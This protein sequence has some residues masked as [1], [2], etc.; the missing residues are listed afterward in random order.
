MKRYHDVR[1]KRYHDVPV[2]LYNPHRK[3]G[4]TPKVQKPWEGPYLVIKRIIDLVYCIQLSPCSRPKVVHMERLW[5]YQGEDPPSWLSH[6]HTH[7][8]EPESESPGDENPGKRE[9]SDPSDHVNKEENDSMASQSHE[10]T[11]DE[12]RQSKRTRH[13]P[14]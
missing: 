13:P 2:W 3:K 12:L 14:E 5:G 11:L 8:Q 6:S 9:E 4:L 1:M 7:L 10:P